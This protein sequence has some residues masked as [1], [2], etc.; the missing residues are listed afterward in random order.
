MLTKILEAMRESRGPLSLRQLGRELGVEE[1][2]LRGM[3]D[4]LARKGY[5]TEEYRDSGQGCRRCEGRCLYRGC[6]RT[7]DGRREPAGYSLTMPSRFAFHVRSS[8]GF[9]TSDYQLR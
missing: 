1:S 8:G 5:V 6:P 2:A 9:R 7:T 3:F 4:Y